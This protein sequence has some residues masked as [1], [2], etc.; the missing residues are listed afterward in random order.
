MGSEPAPESHGRRGGGRGR[1]ALG[2]L[3]GLA[4]LPQAAGAAAPIGL[5]VGAAAGS[6]ADRWARGFA[7]S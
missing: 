6:A 2:A 5:L 3:A 4:L 7:P 1:R